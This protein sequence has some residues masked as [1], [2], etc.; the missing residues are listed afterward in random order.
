MIS[1]SKVLE[2]VGK[3]VVVAVG[4][5]SFNGRIMMGMGRSSLSSCVP[6]SILFSPT[7]LRGD[8]ENTPLQI[9]LNNLAELIAKIG[10]VAGLLLFISLMIRF[11]VQIAKGNPA[12]CVAGHL[13]FGVYDIYSTQDSESERDG[14]CR[15]IDHSCYFDCCCCS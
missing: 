5:K 14:F 8:S 4:T 15:H 9:K 10:S 7:A 1:G 12:R 2:G 6:R 3:Y 11:I 13:F